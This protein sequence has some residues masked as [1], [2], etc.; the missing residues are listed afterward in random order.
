MS[1][2]N[3]LTP[4]F[5]PPL[6]AVLAMSEQKNGSPLTA[7]EVESIRDK[8]VCIMMERADVEKLAAA[9]GYVDVNPDNAWADW[10]RLRAQMIGG[11]LPKII[12]C[13]PGDDDFRAKCEPLLKAENVEYEFRP[14]DPNLA[15]AFKTASMSWPSI[16][17]DEFRRIEAHTTVLYVLSKN[18]AAAEAAKTARA[19]LRVGRRLLGSGGIAIKVESSGIAHSRHR[20]TDFDD[21]IDR[22]SASFWHILFRTFV[23]LPIGSR[24]DLYSCGMHLLGAPDLIVS[25]SL[26]Q[27]LMKPGQSVPAEAAGLFSIFGAYLIGECPVG[28]FASGHTFSCA[29][30]APR[31]RMIWE[32]CEGYAEDTLFFN[33]FGRWR[34]TQP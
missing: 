31:Y 23:Q 16:V 15:R 5:V 12:L 21:L 7:A 22:S 29:A 28:K 4:N 17:P 26:M 32:P 34:F 1:D 20:W 14:H 19:F 24:S 27:T 33:P 10:H 11:Y 18:F 25:T 2:G 6:A 9:R 3:T 30:D 8:S 13:I